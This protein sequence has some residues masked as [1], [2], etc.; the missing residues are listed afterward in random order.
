MNTLPTNNPVRFFRVRATGEL[1][2]AE[3][4]SAVAVSGW[5]QGRF[6][7]CERTH[8]RREVVEILPTVG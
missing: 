2:A 1:F 8:L 5:R 7:W 4:V 6:G 3:I